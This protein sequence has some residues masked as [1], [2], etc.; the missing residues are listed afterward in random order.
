LEEKPSIPKEKGKG[1]NDNVWAG[2]VAI[3]CKLDR[4]GRY[5]MGGE[6]QIGKKRK[7]GTKKRRVHNTAW[8]ASCP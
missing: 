3:E 4:I 6:I 8:A 2:F 1:R 7:E 5:F